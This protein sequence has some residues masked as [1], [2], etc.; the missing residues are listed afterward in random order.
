[1][2]MLSFLKVQAASI[3]GSVVDYLATIVLVSWFHWG[4]VEASVCGNIFGAAALFVLCRKWIFRPDKGNVRLQIVRFIGVFFGNMILA[5]GGI[6]ILT[7]FLH[8]HYIISKTIMSVLLGVSYNYIM[9]KKF[10]FA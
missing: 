1:M 8:I 2:G 9:Q 4:F 5:S 3:A 7:H 6:Y 10:V